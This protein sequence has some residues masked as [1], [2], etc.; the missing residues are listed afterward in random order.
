MGLNRRTFLKGFLTAVAAATAPPALALAASAKDAFPFV[1]VRRL[2]LG[3][4]P[5]RKLAK[6]ADFSVA[7]WDK[8]EV[9]K[10]FDCDTPLPKVSFTA[11]P[12]LPDSWWPGEAPGSSEVQA[13]QPLSG[14]SDKLGAFVEPKCLPS[15]HLSPR[16]ADFS[17]DGQL[18]GYVH[19]PQFVDY[20]SYVPKLNYTSQ[21]VKAA[22]EELK[23][24]LQEADWSKLELRVAAA[25]ET[26]RRE[27]R[28]RAL[29]MG[30]DVHTRLMD[31]YKQRMNWDKLKISPIFGLYPAALIQRTDTGEYGIVRLKK[32]EAMASAVMAV[33][34]SIIYDLGEAFDAMHKARETA[35]V[36]PQA[37]R[38][39]VGTVEEA[40]ELEGG[41]E[42]EPWLWR[43]VVTG[44]MSSSKP[45]PWHWP[46]VSST[47]KVFVNY[48][49][50]EVRLPDPGRTSTWIG[51]DLAGAR[52]TLGTFQPD[53]VTSIIRD[54]SAT[55]STL[56]VTKNSVGP[57][58]SPK[59]NL[60]RSES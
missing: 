28:R 31:Y 45:E 29:D 42:R 48:D 57:R 27:I 13:G 59:F 20:P 15:K 47:K 32:R 40:L 24:I 30:T 17:A 22:R 25:G 21:Q 46:K 16:A 51:G 38:A 60:K 37:V 4:P 9:F 33:H 35:A 14:W 34:D 10:V 23:G 12:Q 7:P 53:M 52:P 6:R 56:T 11:E 5:E 39:W 18:H 49:Q 2:W 54:D 1:V 36:D 55:R 26:A 44:R 8:I 43:T 3:P 41:E 19:L 58:R 50:L